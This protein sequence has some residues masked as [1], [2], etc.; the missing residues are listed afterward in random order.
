[1]HKFWNEKLLEELNK[2]IPEISEHKGTKLKT[3]RDKLGNEDKSMKN[4]F[5]SM[6]VLNK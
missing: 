5:H 2:K 4:N 6:V 1:M 3:V